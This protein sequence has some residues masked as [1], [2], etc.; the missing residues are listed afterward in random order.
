MVQYGSRV[1]NHQQSAVE[2]QSCSWNT[3]QIDAILQTSSANRL[4]A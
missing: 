1:G 3:D 2:V 4:D